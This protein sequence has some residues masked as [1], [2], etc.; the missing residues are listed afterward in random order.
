[1]KMLKGYFPKILK[2]RKVLLM[3][4]LLALSGLYGLVHFL[5]PKGAAKEAI[6]VNH[7]NMKLPE[8]IFD[9]KEEKMTKLDYYKRAD[10]DSLRKRAAMQQDP[11]YQM[12]QS[13][14]PLTG[15]ST[16]RVNATGLIVDAGPAQDERADDLLKKLDQ[17]KQAM[18]QPVSPAVGAVPGA[19]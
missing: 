10:E 8:P 19:A 6:P 2:L 16:A 17:L 3:L 18:Q 12:T 4:S 15:K 9:E 7:F 11:Y 5:G 1:M 13:T 14:Q